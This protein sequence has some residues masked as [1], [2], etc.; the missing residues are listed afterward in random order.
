MHHPPFR[1]TTLLIICLAIGSVLS[2]P[3]S[4]MYVSGRYL[5]TA[6]GEKVVLRGINE[7]AI[8]CPDKTLKTVLPEIAKTGANCA[9]LVWL[10]TGSTATLDTLI[11]NCISAK[12]IPMV[13]MHNATGDWSKLQAS[14][15]GWKTFKPV[16]DTHKKW[17]LLNISNECG[18]GTDNNTFLNY[19]KNAITQLRDAGYTVPLIIDAATWGQD[20]NNITG[21]WS[22]LVNHDPLHNLLFSVHLYW[23]N[24]TENELKQRLDNL[25]G[26]VTNENIPFLFGEGPQLKGGCSTI[27]FPY[28]YTLARCQATEIGWLTWSWGKAKNGDCSAT[29]IY[30]LTTDGAYG[31]WKTDFARE[32]CVDDSNSIQRTSLRPF[33]LLLDSATTSVVLSAKPDNT[34]LG[35]F[36]NPFNPSTTIK[37]NLVQ[38]GAYAYELFDAEG[39]QIRTYRLTTCSASRTIHWNGRDQQGRSV[40]AGVYTGRLSRPGGQTLVHRLLL[41]R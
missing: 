6:A 31:N 18:G 8:W 14:I 9:R 40:A 20:E 36:P 15:D 29:G 33:S 22:A 2:Q 10:P 16:M 17:V 26:K 7:M 24:S 13:E 5:Y 27:D 12:M 39:R 34:L 41:V 1:I 38:S 21:T 19:Y 3:G 11:K 37:F 25:I 35:V 30:D 4:T 28:Q 23:K 32:I